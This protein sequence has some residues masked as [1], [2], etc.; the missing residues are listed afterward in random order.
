MGRFAR[1]G[2]VMMCEFSVIA[3][4]VW[5]LHSV[6][7]FLHV[8]WQGKHVRG[9]GEKSGSGVFAILV[10]FGSRRE[11]LLCCVPSRVS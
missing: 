7:C 11:D 10:E 1:A 2:I 3:L 6:Q 9:R 4:R 5:F 8:R